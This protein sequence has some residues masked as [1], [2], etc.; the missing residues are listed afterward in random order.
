MI[1]A[2]CISLKRNINNQ[3]TIACAV[4]IDYHGVC[5]F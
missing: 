5:L 3:Y 1:V 2:R 4:E